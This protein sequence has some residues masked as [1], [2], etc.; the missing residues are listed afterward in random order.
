MLKVTCTTKSCA[1]RDK[2]RLVVK[3]GQMTPKLTAGLQSQY[4][5]VCATERITR[6]KPKSIPISKVSGI[7]SAT[8]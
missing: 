7:R 5:L 4:T 1:H 2:C 6:S 8:S 3:G